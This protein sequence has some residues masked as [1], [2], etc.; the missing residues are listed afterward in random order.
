MGIRH[1]PTLPYSPWQNG[2]AERVIGSIRRE[3]LDHLIIWNAPHLRRVLRAYAE[4][5][6]R[7]RTH[8]G[9]SKDSP[10]GRPVE[11][12]GRVVSRTVLGGLHHRY[13]RDPAE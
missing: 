13:G 10:D 8:L 2:Y 1:R 11:P 5:Y 9:L 3:A 12:V 7:D 4:Y 6:N